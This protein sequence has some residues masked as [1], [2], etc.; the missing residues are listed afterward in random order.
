[1]KK[2]SATKADGTSSTESSSAVVRPIT[3][4]QKMRSLQHK[5]ILDEEKEPD[6]DT[7]KVTDKIYS[8]ICTL[9]SSSVEN[10]DEQNDTEQKRPPYHRCGSSGDASDILLSETSSSFDSDDEISLHTFESLKREMSLDEG[11]ALESSKQEMEM[12]LNRKEEW[13][14][15]ITKEE[16]DPK[17]EFDVLAYMSWREMT[18]L[19][20]RINAITVI[21]NAFYCLYFLLAGKWLD[22]EVI[23]RAREAM[24]VGDSCAGTDTSFFASS[25]EASFSWTQNM[26][27]YDPATI[28]QE[29]SSMSFYESYEK[30]GCIRSTMFPSL[31]ALPPLPVLAATAGF[32]LHTPFSFM[33][34]WKYAHR[35]PP[36][37]ARIEHWSRRLDHVFMH[38]ICTCMSYATSGSWK[39]FLACA[40]VNADCIYRHFLPKVQPRQNF[41]R[42]GVMITVSFMPILW[43]GNIILFVKIS[44][45]LLISAW[46]FASYPI[47]GWS[48]SAFHVA[49]AMLPPLLMIA[50]CNLSSSRAQIQT[51]AM[52]A[53]LQEKM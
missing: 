22:T 35:L 2:K 5:A 14:L 17:K 40:M 11:D 48:H 32:I 13:A 45:I 25:D 30:F 8:Q 29:M 44:V 41:I 7:Y 6:I 19:Q 52:C 16:K 27:E 33:Y 43:W 36:G 1:M 37:L 12:L 4:A 3:A 9:Y 24:E 49:I 18:P 53:V 15:E 39:Y 10:R 51:A 21:P 26:M 34:H 50:A 38:V 47:G 46:L 42:I 28:A 23:E 20:E 31:H